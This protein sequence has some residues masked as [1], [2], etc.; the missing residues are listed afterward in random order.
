[1]THFNSDSGS[2]VSYAI[3]GGWRYCGRIGRHH[4]SNNV[5]LVVSLPRR[6][7]HQRCFDP[8]CR[9]FRSEPWCIPATVLP[10]APVVTSSVPGEDW[11][12]DAEFESE[13][14]QFFDKWE[15]QSTATT[16]V[17][18]AGGISDSDL[19]DLSRLVQ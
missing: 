3:K 16:P 4:K 9:D 14:L 18:F 15:E 10:P 13:L 5:V 19:E 8:D 1:M 2:V 17:D 12:T 7:M 11:L 6:E